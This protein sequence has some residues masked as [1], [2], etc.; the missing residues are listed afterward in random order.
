VDETA[1]TLSGADNLGRGRLTESSCSDLGFFDRFRDVLC[2]NP[3]QIALQN[4]TRTGR[5]S[6]TY[7]QV[8]REIRAV[9][10]YLRDLGVG[11]G[12]KVG[13]LI[14]NHPRWGIGFLA[15]QSAG[16]V[17]VPLDVLHS[18]ETLAGLI[19]HSEC[20]F[21]FASEKLLP[22][23]K[24]VGE[25]LPEP[26]PALVTGDSGGAFPEW[27]EVLDLMESEE[28]P[29]PL[30]ERSLDDPHVI[31]YTSGTTGDPKGVVL[32][33]RNLYR[34]VV[35]A[36][37]GIEVTSRDHFLG[38][39]PLYHILSLIV[40]FI[41]PLYCGAR[42]SF[43]D[44]LDPQRIMKAFREEGITIFVCV[45]QFYYL[46]YRR[47]LS[48]IERQGWLK[49]ILF[50]RMLALSRFSNRHLGFNAGRWLFAAVHRPFGPQFRFFGVGGARFDPEV[51]RFLTDLGFV[52]VQ[53]YGMT[54]T[55]A[56]A[57]ITPPRPVGVGS[58]GAPL[59]HV[60][61]RIN[62]PDERGVGEILIRGENVMREYF[63]NPRATREAI[64]TEGW[65]HSGDLGYQTADGFVYITGRAKEVIVLGSGK[66]IYPEEIEH[67]YQSNCPFIREMCVVGREDPSSGGQER[68]HAV[69]VPD[70]DEL[71]RQGIVHTRNMIRYLMENLS[72]RLPPYQRVRSFEVWREPLPR[73]TTRKVKRFEI[74]ELLNLGEAAAE[75]NG[76]VDWRPPDDLE[77]RLADL[78][79]RVKPG[80]KA[81]P[82]AHLELDVGLDSLERVEFVSTIQEAFRV[83][84]ADE[85][86]A[87]LVTFQDVADMVRKRLEAP[88]DG[89]GGPRSWAEILD[90]PLGPE[91]S[92]QLSRLRRRP[93]VEPLVVLTAA[94]L[95][96]VAKALF[97]LRGEG[98]ENLPDRY[99][100][101]ICPNHLSFLDAFLLFCLLPPRVVRRSF[102]LGYDQYFGGGLGGFLGSLV[103][104]I[105]VSA[106]RNLRRTLRL[107]AEG[108]RR[109]LVLVVF[110]EG[111]RSIDGTLRPF[112]KGPAILAANFGVPVVPVG[113]RGSYE[114]WPRGSGKI[115]PHPIRIRFGEPMTP[116]AGETVERFNERLW[117]AVRRLT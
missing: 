33:G 62:D 99:P 111:E 34:N 44:V 101:L 43:L 46:L 41:A 55:A 61:I 2:R 30:V 76:G 107:A 3:D 11:P 60:R 112:R 81:H 10:C 8:E 36:L 79:E 66:N 86:A 115:R 49:R 28:A 4:I 91:E 42:S 71:K 50:R 108:L 92:A 57:T 59:P 22:L 16:A 24:Q 64:D 15:A 13:L 23:L 45:P 85:E 14:E 7:A 31:L 87:G 96:L 12:S 93:L 83:T 75:E 78:L 38:V 51:A 21:L 105:P 88:S 52:L 6:I 20:A 37:K 35:E 80:T 117:D 63:K 56:L 39:L 27:D 32:T 94:G 90:E 70:F 100:F 18:P 98:M 104:T 114:A 73:T 1:E 103:K 95:R 97:R 106:D 58:V 116:G 54:E 67:F 47:V 82:Q 109:E 65:L 72:Q 40:N 89:A 5:E 113:I 48:E 19:R 102:S 9:S 68:L 110:P 77:A 84:L 26:L 17:V 69:V 53:A 29:I 74:A 25:L